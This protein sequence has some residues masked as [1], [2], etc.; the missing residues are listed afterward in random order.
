MIFA[1]FVTLLYW[2]A[3]GMVA[4]YLLLLV[5]RELDRRQRVRRMRE[6]RLRRR[7]LDSLAPKPWVRP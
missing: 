3:F 4:L 6:R 7:H 1:S 5:G 2:T